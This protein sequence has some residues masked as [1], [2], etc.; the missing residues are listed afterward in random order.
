MA[1]PPEKS[2]GA[3]RT[4]RE[5]ADWLGV[6]T[7]VLRFWES[8][9]EQIAPVKG[10]GGRRYY[11]PE[12]MLLLGGIKVMLH[13]QGLTIRAV[14]KK[15]EDEGAAPVMDLSPELDVPEG[16]PARTRR[17]IRHGDGGSGPRASR[18]D[19]TTP[20]Q[21]PEAAETI[22][23]E[24]LSEPASEPVQPPSP[25]PVSMDTPEASTPSD[26]R[27][28]IRPDGPTPPEELLPE[29]P[30]APAETAAGHA[31][32]PETPAT[33]EAP[34]PDRDSSPADST[35]IDTDD[36]PAQAPT[37]P[38]STDAQVPEPAADTPVAE[39]EAPAEE[40]AP[41]DEVT[42]EETVVDPAPAVPEAAPESVALAEAAQ[43]LPTEEAC[44]PYPTRTALTLAR[45]SG[46]IAPSN[47]MRLR[48]IV[49][50]YR[51]LA[52]EI[53]EDLEDGVGS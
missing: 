10:A 32:A 53:T 39:I 11:R 29:Q 49:R 51:L 45:Q 46:T 31:P 28:E 13:D 42:A 25:H 33:V 50:R 38:A 34:A 22:V 4:I 41:E 9:F 19:E 23:P 47:K 14:S 20:A 7:H 48:R 26:E 37:D 8:K 44:Q 2:D 1:T 12:D 36:A 40:I 35:P 27:P 15:I 52:E 3:F 16:P 30:D 6:P 21:Q 5:V 43:E 17:V 24:A 18:K